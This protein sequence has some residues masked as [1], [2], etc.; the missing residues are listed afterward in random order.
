M[1]G[2]FGISTTN[3]KEIEYSS[4]NLLENGK[5]IKKIPPVP[6]K[7]PEYSFEKD[8]DYELIM[9]MGHNLIKTEEFKNYIYL[10]KYRHITSGIGILLDDEKEVKE[11]PWKIGN[12]LATK[13]E[14]DDAYRLFINMRN[15]KNAD[16]SYKYTN[17]KAE[18]FKNKSPLRV[19]EEFMI[20]RM[21]EHIREDLSRARA[22]M[23]DF[24]EMPEPMKLIILDFYYNK[25]SFYN[26]YGLPQALK[27]RDIKAFIEK[28]KRPL[29]DRNEWV[30]EQI[31]KIPQNFW[32]E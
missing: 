5:K 9:T 32:S 24:D 4:N 31:G 7:K 20:S 3:A 14:V 6:A 18:F 10:D 15:E 1:S 25:G 22:K 23:Q 26:Q 2:L 27:D 28:M 16:G 11:I 17:Y 21:K 12:R 8:P 13:E 19:S 30:L 29:P